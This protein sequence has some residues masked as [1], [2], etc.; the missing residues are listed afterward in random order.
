MHRTNVYVSLIENISPTLFKK[1]MRFFGT[2]VKKFNMK[3]TKTERLGDNLFQELALIL[4]NL[5]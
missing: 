2:G 5:F 3:I 1:E 4:C